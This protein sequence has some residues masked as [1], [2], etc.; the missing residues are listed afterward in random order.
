MS[1]RLNRFPGFP[2]LVSVNSFSELFG[3]FFG[4]LGSSAGRNQR[5]VH[6]LDDD[7]VLQQIQAQ[8]R[9]FAVQFRV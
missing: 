5:I 4:G 8:L 3:S 6:V 2:G 9:S 7:L 1:P